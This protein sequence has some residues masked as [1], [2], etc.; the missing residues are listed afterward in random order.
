MNWFNNLR[1][2]VKLLGAFGLICM[3]MGFVGYMGTSTAAGVKSNLDDTTGQIVP[4]LVAVSGTQSNFLSGERDLRSAVIDADPK[5]IAADLDAYNNDIVGLDKAWAQFTAMPM[6][7]DEKHL[8]AQFQQAYTSWK[9]V[10]QKV[11]TLA[12]A[13]SNDTAD[14]D[15]LGQ[16]SAPLGQQM[17]TTLDK[18]MAIQAA[19]ADANDATAADEYNSALK[20][21]IGVILGGVVLALGI[22]FY[23]ARRMAEQAGAVESTVTAL[24]DECAA[25]LAEALDAMARQNLTIRVEADA[26]R[27]PEYGN[28]ELGLTAAATNRLRDSLMATLASYETA[29]LGLTELIAEI[30][31]AATGVAETS[32]QLGTAAGQTGA[33]V[34]QVST[35][36]QNVATGAQDTSASAQQTSSAVN[37][38]GGAIDGIARGAAEQ[39]RQ[40]QAASATATQMAAGVEQVAANAQSVA[41]ASVQTKAAAEN[42]RRAVSETT[43]AMVDIQTVVDL[44][45][46]K[47]QELGKLGERIGAVVETID[48][49]AEQTNLLALNAAIE[50]ARAGEHGKG[51]AVVADEVRKLAERSSRE[52]KQ[53]AELIAQVQT[54][55]SEA[56]GAMERG[57]SKVAQGSDKADQ[58]GGALSEILTA[59][60]DT[61]RQ[62]T[63]IATAAHQMSA[64][65]TSVTESMQSISAIVEENTAATEEMAAHSGSVTDSIQSIAAV[66]EEQ[67]AATE[68]VSAS[69]EEMSAQVEEMSAQAQ[70]L[71][72]TAEHLQKLVARFT[73]ETTSAPE[74]ATI[75]RLRRVA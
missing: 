6:N 72:A 75:T 49:I 16:Q 23:L 25:G 64:A 32:Q 19:E 48:D 28:D 56:V 35:A 13:S 20:I 51:F 17:D 1:L 50:A 15:L 10:N 63:E 27:L 40:T 37:Q 29:R 59:V 47:V 26:P 2:R 67:S 58:A 36:I 65:A 3:V 54:G 12:S 34:Q 53:I 31:S 11:A 9:A 42:G 46:N 45:A 22:G 73:V 33:A 41:T 8:A 24:A 21:L 55:T 44:A 69:A 30:Q 4:G 68:E 39:A 70:E 38:L 66:A 57:A 52:T 7:D 60:D 71:A 43:A 61:V 74:V 18:L 5:D 62:V 14:A